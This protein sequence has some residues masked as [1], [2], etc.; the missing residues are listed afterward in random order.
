MTTGIYKIQNT[1]NNKVYI[2]ASIH[3][4]ERFRQHLN[5]LRKGTHANRYLQSAFDNYGESSFE[6]S[7]VEVCTSE[8]LPEAE[9]RILCEY[10]GYKSS[11]TYNLREGGNVCAG[12]ANPNFGKHW[13]ADWCKKQSDRMRE[14]YRDSTNHPMYGKH[15]SPETIEKNRLSHLGTHQTVESNLK[16]S[17]TLKSQNRSGAANPFYGK[18]HS[19]EVKAKLR[20][21]SSRRMHTPEELEKMR[22]A[23][24]GRKHTQATID[25]MRKLKQKYV[26]HYENLEFR[27]ADDL[28]EYLREHGYPK[29]AGSTLTDLYNKGFSRSK[30]YSSLDG[31]IS[32]VLV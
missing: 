4:E 5:E 1:V 22:A 2:G 23:A 18:H 27:C 11:N 26:W 29:I 17:K 16:R 32:R 21:T 12:E 6:F 3:I 14:Y 15:P 20:I 9:I 13:S 24:V 10:G 19:E 31:K 30:T 25:K 8:E 7:I 28:A